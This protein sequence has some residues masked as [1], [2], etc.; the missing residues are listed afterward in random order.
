MRTTRKLAGPRLAILA[1]LSLL[2]AGCHD[3]SSGG[4]GS[5]VAQG[6]S[7]IV[8]RDQLGNPLTA[9]ST[10][11]FSPRQ[12]CGECHDVDHI[13]N[14]YH[15][16]QGRTNA[17]GDIQTADNFNGDGRDWL[18]SDGMYGKW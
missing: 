4:G 13:A 18:K 15:F 7:N 12:T 6:H 1:S 11:P 2:T 10:L 14:G 8:L 9:A 16:Q 17:T 3:S 5:N